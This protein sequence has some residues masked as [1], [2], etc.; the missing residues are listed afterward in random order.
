MTRAVLVMRTALTL[1]LALVGGSMIAEDV[2]LPKISEN[3]LKSTCAGAGGTFVSGLGIYGCST[4]C[5]GGKCAVICDKDE[6]FGTTP[7]N[8]QP[9]PKGGR[10]VLDVLNAT[11]NTTKVRDDQGFSWGLTGLL[12]L[13][14][15]VG[16]V[17]IARSPEH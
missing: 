2:E 5:P 9:V 7:E 10:P 13:I 15:L 16:L 12:G 3:E 4:E 11:P 6:C 8:R 17:K 1:V 14:G